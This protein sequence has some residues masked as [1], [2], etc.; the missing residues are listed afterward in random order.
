[1]PGK[2][3]CTYADRYISYPS[4]THLNHVKWAVRV[5]WC[6]NGKTVS[7]IRHYD[8]M[9]DNGGG[10]ADY[11][12]LVQ[13]QLTYPGSVH[14]EATLVKQAKIVLCVVKYGCYHTY[15]PLERFTL[16]NNGSYRIQ[17]QK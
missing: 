5:D 14:Y 10:L 11:Q 4:T 1:M 13:N 6:Y 7:N 16:G 9:K 8:Y 15:Y 17:Q 2:T 12:G 3:S